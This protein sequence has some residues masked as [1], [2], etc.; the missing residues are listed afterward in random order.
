MM[1]QEEFI[2]LKSQVISTTCSFV[3]GLMHLE[4]D[5]ESEMT[6]KQREDC[7]AIVDLYA[8]SLADHI[9]KLFNLALEK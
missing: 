7:K 6:P 8:P 2:K 3:N 5:D 9:S 4:D 1:Q